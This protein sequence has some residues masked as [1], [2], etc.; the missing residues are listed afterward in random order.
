MTFP[1]KSD[2]YSFERSLKEYN[3]KVLAIRFYMLF[4]S[5]SY[6]LPRLL[7]VTHC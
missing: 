3:L 7:M 2:I 4:V 5:Y 6:E 1:F